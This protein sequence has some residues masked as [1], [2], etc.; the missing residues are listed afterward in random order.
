MLPRV[1]LL[2]L[3]MAL[4]LAARAWSQQL[5]FTHLT[6]E[7]GVVSLPSPGLQTLIQDRIGYVWIGF[8]AA[9]LARYDGHAMELFGTADGLPDLTVR[10]M[11]EDG[12]GRLWVGTETGVVVSDRPF[13]VDGAGERVRFVS[14]IGSA[15]LPRTRIRRNA[16][17]V[18]GDGAVWVGTTG[19]GLFRYR[20]AANGTLLAERRATDAD[21]DGKSET[22]WCLGSKK[23]GTVWAS[24]TS[25][26]V[27]IFAPG[28]TSP[29]LLTSLEGLPAAATTTIYEGP[30]GTLWGGTINGALWRLDRTGRIETIPTPLTERVVS[31]VETADGDLW[32]ASL[33]AG[34]VRLR[35]DEQLH[36]TRRDGLLS[37]SAVV[38]IRDREGTLWLGQY[39]GIS[40]LRHDYE[41]FTFFDAVSPSEA[42]RLDDGPD[43]QTRV[44]DPHVLPDPIAFAVLPPTKESPRLWIGT[45]GGV[46][47]MTPTARDVVT[48]TKEE[49]LLSDEIYS[50]GRDG[51]R[52]WI[53]SVSGLQALSEAEPPPPLPDSQQREIT[54]QAQRGVLT[55][56][57][58]GSTYACRPISLADADGTCFASTSGLNCL[59]GREWFLFG[60]ES[61]LPATGATNLALDGAGY[62]WVGTHTD[63]IYRSSAPLRLSS[64][65]E[66]VA[67][68]RRV[69]AQTFAPVWRDGRVNPANIIRVL[70]WIDGETWVATGGGVLVFRGTRL[71]ARIGVAEGLGGENVFSMAAAPDAKSLWVAQSRGLAQIDRSTRRVIRRVTREDGLVENEAWAYGSLAVAADG[72]IYLATPNGLSLYRPSLD[73]VNPHPPPVRLHRASVGQTDDG[74]NEVVFEYAALSFANEQRVRYKTRLRG[75][76]REWSAPNAT[77]TLRYTNLPAIFV[78]RLYTFEVAAANEDGVWSEPLRYSFAI[79]PPWWLR[80]WSLLS[81]AGLV[82]L[83]G[84]GWMKY[85]TRTLERLIA[86]RTAEVQAHVEELATLDRIVEAINREISLENVLNALLEH[87]RTLFPRAERGAFI[88]FDYQKHVGGVVA[89]SGYEEEGFDTVVTSIED[90][91]EE[92][93]QESQHIGDGVYIARRTGNDGKGRSGATLAMEVTLGGRLEGFLVFENGSDPQA[94]DDSDVRKLRRLREHAI[95][96]VAK[97]RAIEEAAQAN[98]AKSAFLASMS[99]ELR[100]PLNSI[101]GFSEILLQRLQDQIHPR[102]HG[103]LSMIMASGHHLLTIIND[104]LDLSKIEAGK[105]DLHVE[106]VSLREVI[107][108][109]CNITRGFASKH[110]VIIE[111][112][113]PT[114]PKIDSDASK[115]KQILFNLLSNAVKFSPAGAR[116]TLSAAHAGDHVTL[117]VTDRGVGIAREDLP[118]IFEEFRQVG[119]MSRRHIG[120]GLGLSLVKRLAELL[121]GDVTVES[122]VDR[123][124]SF[125]LTLPVRSMRPA[126]AFVLENI[127]SSARPRVLVVEDDPAA[128]EMTRRVLDEAGYAAI[129]VRNG[130]DA[131][132]LALETSPDAITLDLMLPEVDGWSVLKQLK[133]DDRTRHIPV[134]IVSTAD[135][136]GLASALGADDYFTRPFDEGRFVERLHELTLVG[137]PRVLII[138]DDPATHQILREVLVP[139]GYIVEHA[140]SGEEGLKRA[141]LHRPDV[142]VV[143]LLLEGMSGFEVARVFREQ[144]ATATVPIVVLTAADVSRDD[145][146]RLRERI[147]AVVPKGATSAE[148]LL[149]ALRAALSTSPRPGND[150]WRDAVQSAVRSPMERRPLAGRLAGVPR[151]HPWR[152]G[153][154]RTL[155]AC[156]SCQQG[157]GAGRRHDGRLAAGVPFG[158]GCALVRKPDTI[159]TTSKEYANRDCYE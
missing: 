104:I 73:G 57:S 3:G 37:D 96:A 30:T 78:A 77:T 81:V 153:V 14:R 129:G 125:T 42:R 67:G 28:Q 46:V 139:A 1:R 23:D 122:E 33:G 144:E 31:I 158:C 53:G 59:L 157:G 15:Q 70:I 5:P 135:D 18:D 108:G 101:I 83:G 45:S 76:D 10:S 145:R 156:R 64:L 51:R 19:D 90:F 25:G 116:V 13:S 141:R 140:A 68:D 54:I 49:G 107:E 149:D 92:Y 99:H 55:G 9:G 146:E 29:R 105:M 66:Q 119:S 102:M 43:R 137:A 114:L 22:V 128:F 95:S 133:E 72:T 150:R 136:H 159:P 35:G 17:A 50:L 38:M 65:R 44:A 87:G 97:A 154:H 155:R 138:D 60:R 143:D 85:R 24:L 20:F 84:Y 147:S 148:Q 103:F 152:G 113:I 117:T 39:G 12:G 32:A 109:V 82:I 120:T 58:F 52:I 69:R 131:F 121:G 123:G 86:S 106:Q 112:E 111:T 89:A 21:G 16:L 100:T 74:N 115:L 93:T 2:V 130:A 134:V 48:L 7:S 75:Y 126:P 56:Y 63:G 124:S 6:P 34:V 71:V 11:I 80:W 47:A 4:S 36:L 132:R 94:F 127:L 8:Y 98:A 110:E 40:R 62:L 88:I 142:F 79:Q 91:V 61:G 27:M 118:R 41:A 26:P 151:L